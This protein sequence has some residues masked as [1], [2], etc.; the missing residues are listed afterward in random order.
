[1]W[2]PAALLAAAILV[3]GSPGTAEETGRYRDDGNGVVTDTSTGL[4]W[5]RKGDGTPRDW[6]AAIAYCS[7]LDLGGKNNWRLPEKAELS[8]I[9]VK[10][11]VPAIDGAAF[12]D[13]EPDRYWTATTDIYNSGVAWYVHFET[14]NTVSWNK[15][16]E[17]QV[18][19]VS[20]G[21]SQPPASP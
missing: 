6:D 5:Q 4:A 18:R 20:G 1:M 2:L 8:G 17:Y 21:A 16:H 9:V 19:C 13:T 12:P 11:A 7:A 3:T 15:S 10:G 14:G